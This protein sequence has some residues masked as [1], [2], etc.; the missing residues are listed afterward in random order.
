MSGCFFFAGHGMQVDG[1]NYL[2]AV[3]TDVNGE[4]EAKHSSLALNQVIDVMEKA[5]NHPRCVPQQSI[6]TLLGPVDEFSW[7]RAGLR[8]KGNYGR[9]CH[10]SR[11]DCQ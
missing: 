6:R 7:P 4:V 10:L 8:A 5:D 3:D 9:L 2:A 1:S 11:A